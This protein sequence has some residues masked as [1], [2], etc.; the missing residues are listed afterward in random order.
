MLIAD[1]GVSCTPAVAR[2]LEFVRDNPGLSVDDLADRLQLSKSSVSYY[3]KGAPERQLVVSRKLKDRSTYSDEEMFAA[4]RTAWEL[5]GD[6]QAQGLPRVKYQALM[7]RGNAPAAPTF[8]RRWGTWSAACAAAGIQAAKARRPSYTRT[9]SDDD[10]LLAVQ[11]FISQTG[12]TT[13][14]AYTAW[15]RENGRPSGPLVINRHKTWAQARQKALVLADEPA[16]AAAAPTMYAAPEYPTREVRSA[17]TVLRFRG[18][19]LA[20]STSYRAGATRWIE[21]ALHRTEAGT[22]VLSRVGRTVVHH[23]PDCDTAVRARL[24]TIDRGHLDKASQPCEGCRPDLAAGSSVA[25]ESPRYWAQRFDQANGVI[26]ALYKSD[27]Q[28]GQYLTSVAA[29][30]LDRAAEQDPLISAAYRVTEVA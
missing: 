5:L 9:W 21:F 12:Q 18:I 30:L 10:I 11:D 22:Y 7:A 29:R 1:G 17:H 20:T 3:L 4:L 23:T 24:A 27:K 28:G 2:V 8:I 6:R 26:A 25:P 15:A 16:V 14:R 13:F 19:E